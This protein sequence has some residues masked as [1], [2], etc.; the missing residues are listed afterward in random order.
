[1]R[2]R[3]FLFAAALNIAAAT[4]QFGQSRPNS[5][6]KPGYLTPPKEIVEAFDAPKLPQ[7]NLSPSKQVI[8]L[9]SSRAY[10]TIADLSQPMLRLA[11]SRI[12]P[13]TNGP[14]RT[15]GIYSI[16]LKKIAGGSDVKVTVPALA[17]LSNV[18]FSPDGS[19]LSF[20]NTKEN[21]IELWVAD[22]A[23]GKA[24]LVSGADRLH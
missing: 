23:T 17:N 22:A 21:G 18:R 4:I 2:S 10:P 19:Q 14:Q 24:K 7:A 6:T 3:T 13:K 16:T 5:D 20:L 12:D 9:I 15:A 8:A 1:M 11:G